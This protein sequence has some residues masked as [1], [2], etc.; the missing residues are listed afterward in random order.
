MI[1]R[2][3]L[4]LFIAA[5]AAAIA[6]LLALE[7]VNFL[8]REKPEWARA[9]LNE[10]LGAHTGFEL[11]FARARLRLGWDA[12]F[13]RLES[14]RARFA[15]GGG[16]AADSAEF[17]R[18]GE[19]R[20]N[21]FLS[22]PVIDL[23]PGDY[24]AAQE[25]DPTKIAAALTAL[26]DEAGA[27][28]EEYLSGAWR[29]RARKAVLR[30]PPE[31]GAARAV[32]IDDI[33]LRNEG[34][35][36]AARAAKRGEFEFLLRVWEGG[37]YEFF[38][39]W[40]RAPM[41]AAAIAPAARARV[42]GKSVGG[43]FSGFA[44]IAAP[45]LSLDAFS[46]RAA[47]IA[48]AWSAPPTRP[49][50]PRA[51]RAVASAAAVES[52]HPDWR[53][54]DGSVFVA[55]SVSL[56]VDS[57]WRIDAERFV[58]ETDSLSARGRGSA[59]GADWR[60]AVVDSF[61]VAA[62]F[63]DVSLPAIGGKIPPANPDLR[64]AREWLRAAPAAAVARNLRGRVVKPPRGEWRFALAAAVDGGAD[65]AAAQPLSLAAF[66]ARA[67]TIAVDWSAPPAQPWPPRAARA[68][69]RAAGV[70]GAWPG[71]Q[72]TVVDGSVFAAVSLSLGVDSEWRIDAARFTVE[73]DSIS[74]RGRGFAA[75]ADW[76]TAGVDSFDV[77]ARFADAPMSVA[78]RH[79]PASTP[80][81][82]TVRAWLRRALVGG[83]ARGAS[84]RFYM[85][86]DEE[87]D[88]ALA[89]GFENSVLDFADGWPRAQNLVGSVSLREGA[90]RVDGRGDFA[91]ARA[92]AVA[93]IADIYGA[94]T[95][96]L[97]AVSSPH[98][99]DELF[100]A[101]RATPLR[102]SPPKNLRF[103]GAAQVEIEITTALASIS[104]FGGGRAQALDATIERAGLPP[105]K[106]ARGEVE[107]DSEGRVA[108][109]L[110]ARLF[111]RPVAAVFRVADGRI[112]ATLRARLPVSVMLSLAGLSPPGVDGEAGFSLLWRESEQGE[113]AF[114]ASDLSGVAIDLPPPLAKARFA[115][116]PISLALA[117]GGASLLW[118]ING[119]T[120]RARI[121]DGGVDLGLNQPPEQPI[122]QKIT[123][124]G[125]LREL[126]IDGWLALESKGDTQSAFA[127]ARVT[128]EKAH[129]LGWR[130]DGLS[131]FARGEGDAVAFEIESPHLAGRASL[132]ADGDL[133]SLGFDLRRFAPPPTD[134][135]ALSRGG[136]AAQLSRIDGAID[137][138]VFA[139]A[140]FGATTLAMRKTDRERGEWEIELFRFSHGENIF[141]ARGETTA[142]DAKK[143]DSP[144]RTALSISLSAPQLGTL[145]QRMGF[146]DSIE[147]GAMTANGSFSWP[148]DLWDIS[149]ARIRGDLAFVC[150]DVHYIEADI[151]LLKPFSVFTPQA[152]FNLGF[153]DVFE[154]GAVFDRIEG[155]V[156]VGNGLLY[157][158]GGI[159]MASNNL[160]LSMKGS[161]DLIDKTMSVRGRVLPGNTLISG[162]GMLGAF[163]GLLVFEPTLFVGGALLGKIFEKPLS[164]IGAFDY[165]VTGPWDN[166][167]YSPVGEIEVEKIETSDD[168]SDNDR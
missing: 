87:W 24:E 145:V 89:V 158:P 45:S 19:G 73:T 13:V 150:E 49:W 142:R 28:W 155:G 32:L 36:V 63:D 1:L 15:D 144:L 152:L 122:P 4:R 168:L 165:T 21:V 137:D 3:L 30:L 97:R 75:G 153:V 115:A 16:M 23:P 66:S 37:A 149:R 9:R 39:D 116:A 68:L 56:G 125:D 130:H 88:F 138:F 113:E 80:N 147:S 77:A 162:G 120:L 65:F 57:E 159:E 111:A 109:A 78:W 146:G 79:V 59:A 93:E 43:S 74:L 157:S 60:T 64:A 29:A 133:S 47:T 86:P 139:D 72:I 27:D 143:R 51:A 114:L 163:S 102:F 8:L 2:V 48:V 42:W 84:V 44:E 5:A 26:R 134:S 18:D 121:E 106:N 12:Q 54:L 126:D 17:W 91:G 14:P 25:F 46:A 112:D 132:R 167:I 98:E 99:V 38:A 129:W 55:A 22:A 156:A 82:R 35:L 166:P 61:D 131:L 11:D 135:D 20:L 6:A 104:V 161:A 107:F 160:F 41:V 52:A 33:S 108:G 123:A 70:E 50:P 141:S 31:D 90:M 136:A 67:A 105:L 95:L 53:E 76:R 83:A 62:R 151:G 7:G 58:V 100:A 148:G 94:A 164:E 71:S 40:P 103:A 119:E 101:A 140:H 81:L 96:G 127:V 85:P 110:A 128:I 117:T 154:R 10:M 124:R 34:G 118:Q 92:L 69:A